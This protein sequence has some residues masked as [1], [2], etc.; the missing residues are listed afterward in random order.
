MKNIYHIKLALIII[1]LAKFTCGQVIAQNAKGINL[2][3]KG[4]SVSRVVLESGEIVTSFKVIPTSI[5][6]YSEQKIAGVNVTVDDDGNILR[7]DPILHKMDLPDIPEVVREINME[8]SLTDIF[9][10]YQFVELTEI[11]KLGLLKKIAISILLSESDLNKLKINEKEKELNACLKSFGIE[12]KSI[13]SSIEIKN[14]ARE[15]FLKV[16]L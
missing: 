3:V 10:K 7:I 4:L 15:I 8:K 2:Y 5:E 9:Q 14:L 13:N 1:C 11:Q 12:I 16:S 6:S